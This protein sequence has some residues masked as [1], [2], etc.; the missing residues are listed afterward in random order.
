M[1]ET[2]STREMDIR[3]SR[4]E[5]ANPDSE[6]QQQSSEETENLRWKCFACF[7]LCFDLRA[8][9]EEAQQMDG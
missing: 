4:N 1:L 3:N 6:R 8:G 2:T 5:E 9:Q 7:V